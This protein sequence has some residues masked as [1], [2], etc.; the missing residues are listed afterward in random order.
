MNV[1]KQQFKKIKF[2]Q[3]RK[4][5][6]LWVF[7]FNSEYF[8]VGAEEYYPKCYNVIDAKG[9]QILYHDCSINLRLEVAKN[10]IIINIG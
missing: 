7:V 3:K 5:F 8:T 6:R 1:R 10:I 2:Q 9:I 4:H